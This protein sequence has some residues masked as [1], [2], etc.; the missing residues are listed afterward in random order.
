MN[1]WKIGKLQNMLLF[2]EKC[3]FQKWPF[4]SFYSI[5]L[6][7]FAFFSW[8]FRMYDSDVRNLQRVGLSIENFQGVRF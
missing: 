1:A 5:K 7:V 8:F 6:T 4:D 2:E 3:A